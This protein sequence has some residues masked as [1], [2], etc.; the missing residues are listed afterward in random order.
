MKSRILKFVLFLVV[1]LGFGTYSASALY[2]YRDDLTLKQEVIKGSI[3]DDDK[4]SFDLISEDYR[5]DSRFKVTVKM[6]NNPNYEVDYVNHLIDD[7]GLYAYVSAYDFNWG[8]GSSY[9]DSIKSVEELLIKLKKSHYLPSALVTATKEVIESAEDTKEFRLMDYLENIPLYIH[10]DIEMLPIEYKDRIEERED[11]FDR[12]MPESALLENYFRFPVKTDMKVRC[13]ATFNG[14]EFETHGELLPPYDKSSI[15]KTFTYYDS[16]KSDVLLSFADT[17]LYHVP[18]DYNGIFRLPLIKTKRDDEEMFYY[19]ESSIEK[20]YTLAEDEKVFKMLSGKKGELYLISKSADKT[21]VSYLSSSDYKLLYK[22]DVTS[23]SVKD[24]VFDVRRGKNGLLVVYDSGNFCWLDDEVHDVS[25]C[26]DTYRS[27]YLKTIPINPFSQRYNWINIASSK[28]KV[29]VL[30][31]KSE[32]AL[33]T[34]IDEKAD[35]TIVK[36]SFP[37]RKFMEEK[38]SPENE[39]GFDDVYERPIW[40]YRV[41]KMGINVK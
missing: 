10:S 36:Y 23:K 14:R 8:Y 39:E 26:C 17:D 4:I 28:N 40:L 41:D 34:V 37:R 16:A 35:E 20:V 25:I 19:D 15:I 11:S 9:N 7:D 6:A 1:V 5:Y 32:Y 3:E 21:Y 30:E 22:V 33:L 12:I 29:Y 13:T 38:Q 31:N 2:S 24:D 27:D 18:E